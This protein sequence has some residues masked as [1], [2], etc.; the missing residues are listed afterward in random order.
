MFFEGPIPHSLIEE[1]LSTPDTST[2]A[3]LFFAG[4][5]RDDHIKDSTVA[6]IEFTA[7]QSICEKIK[8]QII[9]ESKR[10]HKIT[11]AKVFHSLGVV[12]TGKVCFFVSVASGHRKEG[13]AALQFI[14]DEVKKRCPIFGKELL[15]NGLHQWKQNK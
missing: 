6:A 10:I 8:Q 14:V 3:K 2:G 11:E 7:Q 5:V 9:D 1:I 12:E 4:T 13:Y 15:E